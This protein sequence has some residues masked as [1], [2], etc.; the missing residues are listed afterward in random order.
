[1]NGEKL[2]GRV[3][4]QIGRIKRKGIREKQ[5]NEKK[6]KNLFWGRGGRDDVIKDTLKRIL[7]GG[8][9]D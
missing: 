1:M 9:H 8:K 2:L 5:S 3:G 6:K 7:D 4:C